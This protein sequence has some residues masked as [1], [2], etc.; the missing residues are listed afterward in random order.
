MRMDSKHIEEI[1]AKYWEGETSLAE[2]QSLKDFF[3][4]DDSQIPRHLRE[5]ATLF[6]YFKQ[7]KSK[8]IEDVVM[9]VGDSAP[10]VEKPKKGK[11]I[12]FVRNSLR[13]A[14]G[15]AVLWV[16]VWMVRTEI[17]SSTPQEIVDTYDDPEL[18]FEE[19]KK[20]LLMISKSFGTAERQA[21]KINMFNEAQ[22]QIQGQGEQA[23]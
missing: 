21:R 23:N 11:M 15:I 7:Q 19:T 3:S 9:P 4:Q 18:A 12:S 1:L 14:A 2:E 5:T 6:R 16:A 17:R 20:A 8:T 13:I 22:E 10:R